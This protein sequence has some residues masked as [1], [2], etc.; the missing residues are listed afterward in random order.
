MPKP[1]S[2]LSQRKPARDRTERE[3]WELSWPMYQKF[4]AIQKINLMKASNYK[5]NP[6]S[7]SAVEDKKT[8]T[9]T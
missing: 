2:D 8:I 1:S 4:I 6:N 9:D 7:I 5:A 3:A